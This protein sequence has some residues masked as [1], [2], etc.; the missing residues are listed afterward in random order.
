ML[1]SW[2][3]K[4]LRRRNRTLT[5][6]SQRTIFEIHRITF[7]ISA[8]ENPPETTRSFNW[9]Y[10]FGSYQNFVNLQLFLPPTTLAPALSLTF[11]KMIDFS[12][13]QLLPV[14]PCFY[15]SNEILQKRKI[16]KPRNSSDQSSF[17]SDNPHTPLSKFVTEIPN[18]P[19]SSIPTNCS[20]SF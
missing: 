4:R 8:S 3:R 5:A 9:P 12:G 18:E 7:T 13:V 2:L 17:S 10:I 1:L 19:Q 6:P 14:P 11:V 20:Y 15:Q 16:F